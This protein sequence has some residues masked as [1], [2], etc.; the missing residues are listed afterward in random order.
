MNALLALWLPILLSAVVIFIISSILHMV[1]KGWH[2]SDYKGFANEDAVRAAINAGNPTPGRYVVPYCTDSKDWG[3]EAMKQKYREGPVGHLTLGP[4]GLPN[5]G[6]FLG[7]W[8]VWA[9]IVSAIAAYV[10]ARVYGLNPSHD[11]RAAK[12]IGVII[13]A[14]LGFGTITESIWAMRPWVTSVKYLVDSALYGL[15]S[16]ATFY[17]LWP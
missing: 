8:F 14:G 2:T 7:Q 12:L 16:A 4:I 17:W 11:C 6:K 13:F 9:L 10:A 15:G 5:L 3:S 1:L